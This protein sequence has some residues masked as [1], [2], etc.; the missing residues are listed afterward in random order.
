MVALATLGLREQ[1]W[2]ELVQLARANAVDEW[3]FSEWFHGRTLAPAGMPG[4]SWNAATY[5]LALRALAEPA[6]SCSAA[7][8]GRRRDEVFGPA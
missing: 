8:A 5:L 6:A 1:A 7:L 4:Q 3:R 2:T